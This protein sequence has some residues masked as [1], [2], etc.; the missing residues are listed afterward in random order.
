M[1]P[2]LTTRNRYSLVIHPIHAI[3]LAGTLPLFL[4]ATLSDLAYASSYHI[5]WNNFASW[6]IA[7]GL[8]FTG[9]ALVLAIVDLCQPPRRAPGVVPYAILLAVTWI[10]GFLN[11]LMHAR[12]AWASMPTGLVLS[13]IVLILSCAAIWFG[14]CTPRMGE[15]K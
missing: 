9:V 1:A 10:V 2:P 15:A 13:V 4:G 7:A 5:Q 6:L 3:I 14:F 8:V 11:A 12:D